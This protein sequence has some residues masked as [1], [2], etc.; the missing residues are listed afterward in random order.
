M[1]IDRQN[2]GHRREDGLTSF[3]AHR[4]RLGGGGDPVNHPSGMAVSLQGDHGQV[5]DVTVID[6]ALG[7]IV[8]IVGLVGPSGDAGHSV[9]E[10]DPRSV[11]GGTGIP[12]I[13]QFPFAGH[14][15]GVHRRIRRK[16]ETVVRGRGV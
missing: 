5:H 15:V 12:Q 4:H 2:G 9:A 1:R 13:D 11:D 16:S 10:I 7:E 6:D 3:Q 14:E 8:S